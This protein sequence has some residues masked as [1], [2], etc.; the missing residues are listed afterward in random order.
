M[1]GLFLQA[2]QDTMSPLATAIGLRSIYTT[3]RA[4]PGKRVVFGCAISLLP[5]LGPNRASLSLTS[6]FDLALEWI[7]VIRLRCSGIGGTGTQLKG[8]GVSRNGKKNKLNDDAVYGSV[9]ERSSYDIVNVEL[10]DLKPLPGQKPA[11]ISLS[12]EIMTKFLGP[13]A[14]PSI[15]PMSSR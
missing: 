5:V 7:V 6:H 8:I 3:M 12:Y 4:P 1:N 15:A 11:Q 2:S 10:V 13:T 9:P 14:S